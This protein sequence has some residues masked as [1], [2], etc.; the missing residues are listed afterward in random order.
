M[1][2]T[3][4]FKASA[5]KTALCIAAA[6][7]LAA[8]V[9]PAAAQDCN[10]LT[11]LFGGCRQARVAPALPAYEPLNVAPQAQARAKASLARAKKPATPARRHKAVA[12]KLAEA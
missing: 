2:R 5:R 10:P 12:S 11:L 4:S 1:T 7:G 6:I 3:T 9:A 8:S